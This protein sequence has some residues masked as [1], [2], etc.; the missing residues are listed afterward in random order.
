M[1]HSRGNGNRLSDVSP[2]G[3]GS[4]IEESHTVTT[5]TVAVRWA[6][7]LSSLDSGTGSSDAY[8]YDG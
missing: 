5:Q 2:A 7:N 4:S 6:G 8:N 1:V 3:L